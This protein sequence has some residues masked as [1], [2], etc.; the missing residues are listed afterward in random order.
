MQRQ[1][2]PAGKLELEL[3]FP[4]L[5]LK[6][7]SCYLDLYRD[8]C[9]Y[10][11]IYTYIFLYTYICITHNCSTGIKE[12]FPPARARALCQIG[13]ATRSKPPIHI[14]IEWPSGTKNTL[15][16]GRRLGVVEGAATSRATCVHA[17]SLG[18]GNYMHYSQ[19]LHGHKRASSTS[20]SPCPLSN[21]LCH[22]K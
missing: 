14:E 12:L 5:P 15:S 11:Y 6:A 21:W 20:Q 2:D 13:S 3:E 4:A 9:I 7:T 10:I 18:A 16:H 8:I 17:C 22:S 19:L 1:K